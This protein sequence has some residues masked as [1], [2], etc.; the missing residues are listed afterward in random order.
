M[1]SSGENFATASEGGNPFGDTGSPSYG[2]GPPVLIFPPSNSDEGGNPYSTGRNKGNGKA[3]A[4]I[5]PTTAEAKVVGNISGTEI[6]NGFRAAFKPSGPVREQQLL[7]GLTELKHPIK[8]VRIV[9]IFKGGITIT[10]ES[11]CI[12]L[13]TA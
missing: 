12:V 9:I 4:D 8:V 3:P 2:R 6:L 13:R 7:L 10:L 11:T 1:A 5:K